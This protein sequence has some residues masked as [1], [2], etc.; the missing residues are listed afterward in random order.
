VKSRYCIRTWEVTV[1]GKFFRVLSCL[2]EI[3][4]NQQKSAY[5]HREK[6]IARGTESSSTDFSYELMMPLV[7]AVV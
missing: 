6:S 4:I 2:A 7:L 5:R 1:P 3:R